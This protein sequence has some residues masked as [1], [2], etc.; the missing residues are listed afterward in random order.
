MYLQAH[1]AMISG[2]REW[3]LS[4][5]REDSALHGMLAQVQQAYLPDAALIVHWEGD[6]EGILRLLPHLADKP[7]VN[8]RAT[9]YVCRN[10]ACRAPVTSMEAVRE[11]LASSSREA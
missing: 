7:A 6:Q 8:G 9:A 10:F 1:L 2:G 5:K 3:V 11:L 4:G